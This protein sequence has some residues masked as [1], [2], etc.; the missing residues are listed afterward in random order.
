MLLK[1]FFAQH[2]DVKLAPKTVE[3]YHEQAAYLDPELLNMPI[4]EITPL[5]FERE[6]N[7][8]LKSGGHHRGSKQPRPLSAKTVRN[9]AG[10]VSSAFAKAIK[11]GLVKANPVSD[12]EPPVPK[13][14]KGVGL[15]VAQPLLKLRALDVFR[16]Q[17]S[18]TASPG[19][20]AGIVEHLS[21]SDWFLFMASPASA[22]SV[23]CN[24]EVQWWI[25]N[26]SPER[27]LVLLTEGDI[28]W[29]AVARDFDW[30]RTNS[31]PRLLEGRCADEPLYVDLR[32]ARESELLSLR[33]AKFREA[34]VN[35]AAPIRGIPKD[36]LD[37]ADLRQLAR[38]RGLVRGGIAVITIAAI[39]AI[40]QAVVAN[41][42]RA[43]AVRQRDTAIARQLA[44]T[45]E[46][47]ADRGLDAHTTELAASLAVE[48]WKRLH[49][50]AATEVAR[51]LVAVLP[52][53]LLR[54]F[55]ERRIAIGSAV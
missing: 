2:V 18:L 24:K 46:L 5:H 8:L 42:Q 13:K 43:E 35:V 37:G 26:R 39:V 4:G 47:L 14:R 54:E 27:M 11:W 22:A 21:A 20:W 29:D 33:N 1:E 49:N 38:N 30:S 48:S 34:V 3:R 19:L 15:T 45:A 53:R 51:K 55:R 52:S 25:E 12:S 17:T 32:W 44:T 16:D 40:W 28:A 36:Q 7:R 31:L 10:V 50:E 9:V 23:W 6:W 41:Q